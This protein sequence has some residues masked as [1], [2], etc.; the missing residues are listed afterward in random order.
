MTSDATGTDLATVIEHLTAPTPDGH[1]MR[2]SVIDTPGQ[3]EPVALH[4]MQH[5]GGFG[6]HVH[7]KAEAAARA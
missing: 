7:P 6:G 2:P 5:F 1:A 3:L 4:R